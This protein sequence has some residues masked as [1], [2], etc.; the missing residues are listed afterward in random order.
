MIGSDDCVVCNGRGA[1]PRVQHIGPIPFG[2]SVPDVPMITCPA[3][4]GTGSE[5]V[6]LQAI[7]PAV[8]TGPACRI[9]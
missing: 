9:Q 3:C 7:L 1:L 8:P 4:H 5:L 2:M 6:R